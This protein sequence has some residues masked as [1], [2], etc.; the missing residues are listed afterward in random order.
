MIRSTCSSISKIGLWFTV[1]SSTNAPIWAKGW[2]GLPQNHNRDW[3]I[4]SPVLTVSR[5]G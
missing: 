5:P 3:S 1:T 2:T 4:S